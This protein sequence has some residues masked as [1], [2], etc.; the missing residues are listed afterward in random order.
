MFPKKDKGGLAT[1][2]PP[3]TKTGSDASSE[4]LSPAG[5]YPSTLA[6]S[7][8]DL[9]EEHK[10][11]NSQPLPELSTDQFE[12]IRLTRPVNQNL[13]LDQG[14]DFLSAVLHLSGAKD[15][16]YIKITGGCLY[17]EN[18]EKEVL[19]V[20]AK[21]LKGYTSSSTISNKKG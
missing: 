16:Y 3:K 2:E 10:Q 19:D 18:A 20:I 8:K 17:W 4:D 9:R 13:Y 12:N 7:D 6:S 1:I 5:E 14:R 21:A 15:N 11:Q